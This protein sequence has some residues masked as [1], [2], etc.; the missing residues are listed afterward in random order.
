M[1][2]QL[3]HGPTNIAPDDFAAAN[4][5]P[6]VPM[7][8][9]NCNCPRWVDSRST[10]QIRRMVTAER[11]ADAKL[12]ELH[13]NRRAGIGRER[14]FVNTCYSIQVGRLPMNRRD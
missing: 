9:V 14:L 8:N 2:K 5:K 13:R 6:N 12:A 11:M 7:R 10:G 4:S 3:D 1:V